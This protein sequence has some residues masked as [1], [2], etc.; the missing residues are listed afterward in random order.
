MVPVLLRSSPG[1]GS[2]WSP[3]LA[4][5]AR[6]RR[7]SAMGSIPRRHSPPHTPEL[8]WSRRFA[9]G[10]TQVGCDRAGEGV[11]DKGRALFL[12]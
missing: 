11:T 1:T 7:G 2:P 8:G 6:G 12:P 3:G 4:Q 9:L 5:A 10:I